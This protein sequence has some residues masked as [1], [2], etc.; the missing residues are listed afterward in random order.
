MS[1]SSCATGSGC[2]VASTCPLHAQLPSSYPALP[3]SL[4]PL[5]PRRSPAA[6]VAAL[7]LLRCLPDREMPFVVPLLVLLGR[8]V[9]ARAFVLVTVS[10]KRDHLGGG[11]NGRCKP[12]L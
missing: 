10:S 4:G 11:G 9:A 5:A 6:T 2:S 1:L 7:F 8:W 12:L 3:R